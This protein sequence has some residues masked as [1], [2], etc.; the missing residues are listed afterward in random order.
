MRPDEPP[1]HCLDIGSF[2]KHKRRQI[3]CGDTFVF[4]RIREENRS[5]AVLSDGL[6]SG[7]K[8]N[9]LSTLTATMALNYTS[10]FRDLK[11]TAETI[12]RTLPECSVR[13]ISYATFCIVDVD[14]R[15]EARI[16]NYDSPS[17]VLIRN[18]APLAIETATIQG[19]VDTRSYTLSFSR[20]QLLFGDRIVVFSDG[21]SQ[22]GIG[23]KAYPLGWEVE[24]AGR[25]AGQTI[26][27]DPE[28]SARSL[29]RAVVNRALEIDAG[30]AF[31]DITCGVIHY[32]KPRE[33][34]IVSGP[35]VAQEKD[36]E[37]SGIIDRFEGRTII[38]GGT[39]AKIVGRELGR[40]ISFDFKDLHP[41]LPPRSHMDGIDLVT[42]GIITL[43]AV[44]ELLEA[45][46]DPLDLPPSPARDVLERILES[47]VIRFLVGTR[48]NEAWQDPTLPPDIGLRRTII[49]QITRL[50]EE[51]YHK[52]TRLQFV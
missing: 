18:G 25:F 36:R 50:L 26:M 2:Q 23:S 46:K 15:G 21:V 32:R 3:V 41:L 51:K 13:K 6:G 39:T 49:R 34:L 38:C 31:D 8:A 22:A 10:G 16:I 17:P 4:R 19:A 43:H 14:N 35:P 52:E 40:S 30:S 42:E 12:M 5:I 1:R 11:K 27:A 44:A 24:E 47:D 7:V 28:C 20:V 48:I 9:V 45:G 33:L 37:L 29:S